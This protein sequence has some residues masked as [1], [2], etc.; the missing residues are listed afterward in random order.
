MSNDIRSILVHLDGP[1][2]AEERLALGRRLA[3][4]HGAAVA[5]LYATIP[6]ALV[7][8]LAGEAAALMMESLVAMDEER[9]AKTRA[10][11]DAMV[12]QHGVRATW[13][14]VSHLGAP[15]EAAHC[16]MYADLLVLGQH[17]PSVGRSGGVPVHFVEDILARSG[18]PAIVV[19]YAG[20]PGP[21][22]QTV[23]IAWKE[24][25]EAS[26]ALA[27]AIPLFAKASDIHVLTWGWEKPDV[28]RPCTDVVG[29]L[30]R[31]GIHAQW[32]QQGPEA[33]DIGEQILSR[34]AD[35][36]ADLLVMGC[37]GH[38]RAREWLLGGASRS[39]LQSMTLPVL[40]AH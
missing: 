17:D 16:A 5:V 22:F 30:A 37:Y 32:H 9:R 14:E 35:L 19:P 11:F 28:H 1:E 15:Q 24:T 39:L 25:A 34:C 6:S 38:M 23:A 2:R 8:P 7:A 36:S 29:Y 4:E 33:P 40:M 21:S 26:R 12:G 10:I 20:K 31:H 3:A 27:A 18:R 13:G